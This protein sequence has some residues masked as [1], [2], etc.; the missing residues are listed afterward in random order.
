MPSALRPSRFKQG[1]DGMLQGRTAVMLQGRNAAGER[2][3]NSTFFCE[4]VL[5][6]S[7]S[8]IIFFLDFQK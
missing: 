2:K 6:K 1:A 4:I 8:A 5:R 3:T 7:R